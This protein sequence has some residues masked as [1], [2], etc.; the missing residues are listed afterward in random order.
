MSK[1]K[2]VEKLKDFLYEFAQSVSYNEEIS[3]NY[4]EEND[5]DVEKFVS[6][7]IKQIEAT[8]KK[9]DVQKSKALFFKRVVL[10]AEIVYNLYFERTFGHVKLQKLMYLCEQ[11]S[12]MELSSRYTKQAAGPYD[13][14]FMHSIDRELERQKWFN[15]EIKQESNYRTYEYSLGERVD[16][17][18]AYY[19]NYYSENLDSIKWLIETFRKPHT[20]KVELVATIYS[21]LEEFIKN[22]EEFT[23]DLLLQ[24]VMDWS[25]E[26]KKKFTPMDVS[27]AHEWMI[28]KGLVPK[29]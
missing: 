18:K 25:L 28:E 1:N 10:A 15:I 26:K 20:K 23:S 19:N 2:K 8:L 5:I 7:G 14:K 16:S 11:V 27:N 6:K 13:G 12:N 9:K 3:K 29:S 17:Y 21:C 4:L 24:R 22:K